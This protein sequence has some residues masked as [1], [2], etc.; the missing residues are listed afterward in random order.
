MGNESLKNK[1]EIVKTLLAYGADPSVLR[2]GAQNTPPITVPMSATAQPVSTKEKVDDADDRYKR[3]SIVTIR[4]SPRS[5]SIPA[6]QVA[7]P[8]RQ[9]TITRNPEIE[10]F[11][12]RAAELPPKQLEALRNA[13]FDPLTR[14]PF[15]M[16]GQ[17]LVL[18]ELLRVLARHSQRGDTSPVSIIF[19]GPSGHGK[20][21]LSRSI[22]ELLRVPAHTVNMTNLRTQDELLQSR[23]LA[24][25]SSENVNLAGFLEMHEGKRCAVILEEIE[26]VGDKSAAN[27]LLMP[28]ELGKLN[29]PTRV[30]DTS[31]VIWISTSNAGE[32]IVFDFEQHRGDRQCTRNE[33]L[34]L[35]TRIRRRLIESLGA[36]LVSRITTVLPF[37]AFTDAEKLA[38][39]HQHLPP[40]TLSNT[41]LDML[42]DKIIQDYIPSE[43]VRSIQRAVERHYEEE[44]W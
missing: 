38:L 4:P 12:S 21:L 15:R 44:L 42:L 20:S 34:D 37:L 29:T 25:A 39:A 14:M 24:T 19:A 8:T 22:G 1:T 33:Y 36:S 23:S 28:W 32:D 26:K 6:V 9:L 43:G 35:A 2:T 16:V 11:M 10:Y 40:H 30:Y 18:Q 7:P 13:G 27:T 3:E 41:E 17:D 31:K 5:E